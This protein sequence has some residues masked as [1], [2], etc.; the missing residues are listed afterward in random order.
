MHIRNA[1]RVGRRSW[2][3]GKEAQIEREEWEGWTGVWRSYRCPHMRCMDWV[4]AH[5]CIN[6]VCLKGGTNVP[7][8]TFTTFQPSEHSGFCLQGTNQ[9]LT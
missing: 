9:I 5:H 6:A 8:G 4:S 3:K 1:M 7:H 2:V